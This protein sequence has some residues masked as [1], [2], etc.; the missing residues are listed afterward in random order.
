M[1]TIRPSRVSPFIRLIALLSIVDRNFC[2][3]STTPDRID[4]TKSNW[5]RTQSVVQADCKALNTLPKVKLVAAIREVKEEHNKKYVVVSIANPTK[6][7][8]CFLRLKLDTGKGGEK[9]L[10][11]LWKENYFTLLP[12]ETRKINASYPDAK[13]RERR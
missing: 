7:I 9:I 13:D 1:L 2:W 4:W 5:Y 10:P 11:V 3:L 6:N 12:G 8:A